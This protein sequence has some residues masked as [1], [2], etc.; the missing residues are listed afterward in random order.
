MIKCIDF[1]FDAVVSILVEKGVISL[2][3]QYV[4]ASQLVQL[5]QRSSSRLVWVQP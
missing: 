5:L 4:D 3:E 2:E 1:Y